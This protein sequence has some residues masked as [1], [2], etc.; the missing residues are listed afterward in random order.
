[1]PL[2]ET[3]GNATA[4]AYGG[5][6]AAVPNYIEDVFSTYLYTGTG[7]TRT[8]TNGI[9]LSTK[10]GMVWFKN[11]NTASY[12]HCLFDTLSGATKYLRSNSTGVQA[13][14]ANT[15][16]AFNTTGFNLGS[17]SSGAG[18]NQ[19]TSNTYVSWTF[20]KQPKFFDVVTW[21]GDGTSNRSIPHNL[22]VIPGATISRPYSSSS[23]W[24]FSHV[25]L[26]GKGMFLNLTDAAAY[27]TSIA[28]VDAFTSTD[29]NVTGSSNTSGETYIAYLY[30]SDSGGF[31]LTG[32]DNVITCGS[33]TGTGAT[34]NAVTLG[35]EPQWI[36]VKDSTNTYSW[37]IQDVMRGMSQTNA[38]ILY[39]DSASA[40][41]AINPAIVPT[42]TGFR[43]N[44]T[45]VTLNN[46]GDTYIYIAIR[47][48]PMKVPTSA[49]LY[50]MPTHTA[51]QEQIA[52]QLVLLLCLILFFI[53]IVIQHLA[54][55]FIP[56]YKETEMV[57][58][59]MEQVLNMD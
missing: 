28:P 56:V 43:L 21:T 41:V 8:I 4:D 13:T 16:T 33:Y 23:N 51:E 7:A 39:P 6:V 12:N 20:R 22:G 47:R 57:Y 35:F 32:T 2:Q 38:N 44:T 9:N 48:G 27:T 49:Q 17:D 54:R 5:G 58:L 26:S 59:Q 46:S 10:G 55:I 50:L 3:S 37:Q 24:C 30:A 53:L 1:M 40:E 11:R 36:L 34:G 52:E 29:F 45:N 15:L 14:D 19:G 42:A 31:G 25:A 18:V